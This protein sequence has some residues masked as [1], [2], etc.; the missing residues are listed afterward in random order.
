MI[1]ACAGAQQDDLTAICS[2]GSIFFDTTIGRARYAGL[3]VRVEKR[4]SGRAQFLASYA[5]GSYVGSN[6][7]GTGTTENPG[8]RVFGFNNDDWFENYGPLP[9][10]MRHMLNLSGI[11]ELPWRLQVAFSVSAYSR[12][13][14]A[15]YVAAMDF[16]GDGTS[17]DL[18]PGTRVNQFGRGLDEDDLARLVETYNEQWADKPTATGLAPRLTLPA[19]YSFNDTFFTQDVR[20]TRAFTPGTGRVRLLLLVEVFNLFNTANLVQY[21]SDLASPTTFGQP[22]ARFTQIFGSGGPRAFQLGARVTF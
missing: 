13:P 5:L 2:N 9:T 10:D 8:G 12:P 3:L 15:A 1:P 4:I 14:F 20:V 6:G 19:S 18:L 21:G 16:N 11:V 17:N 7:T 22:G